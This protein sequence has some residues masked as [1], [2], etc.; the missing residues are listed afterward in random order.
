[1]KVLFLNSLNSGG[2]ARAAKR[3]TSALEENGTEVR[4]ICNRGQNSDQNQN[5]SFLYG[6][7]LLNKGG[8]NFLAERLT[9]LPKERDKSVRFQF[10]LAN[11]GTDISRHPWVEWADVIHIHWINQGFL[12]ISGLEQLGKL[13]IPIV[14]TFHDMWAFTGGCHHARN[15]SNFERSCGN[16]NFLKKPYDNDISKSIWNKKKIAFDIFRFLPVTCS[17]WL[18]S[19]ANKSSLL[20]NNAISIPNPID[21][22]KYKP[23]NNG[24]LRAEYG[25]P[26]NRFLL[27]FAA[28]S[29]G[30]PFK[31]FDYL[32]N[33]IQILKDKYPS[34]F[35]K[36]DLLVMG[37]SDEE[38]FRDINV[39]IHN[40]GLLSS[41][42]K[43]IEAYNI[44]D[45]YLTSSLEENLPN[46]IMEAMSCG[47]PAV[48]FEVGGIPEMISN[49]E[50]GFLAPLRNTEK[51]ADALHN[52][53]SL[54]KSA[55]DKMSL[56]ARRKVLNDYGNSL[57]AKKYQ[58]QYET[59]LKESRS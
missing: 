28:M 56:N 16:C 17:D 22:E 55:Y 9:F 13:N 40:L 1:M 42:K 43:I 46:T 52:L 20:T 48:A 7:G 44:S 2:A 11:F 6:E 33:A 59:L 41:E 57:V 54:S 10:S 31:G 49:G 34:S 26:E 39:P 32:K 45:G 24:A 18:A 21:T 5:V 19:E 29:L 4:M 15:C 37:N 30:N 14:W 3:L 51:L 23:I 27:L 50:T 35:N 12:S 53:I 36:L 8:I 25:I 58:Y 38:Y 47:V